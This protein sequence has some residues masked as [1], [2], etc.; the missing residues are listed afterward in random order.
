MSY[1]RE[2]IEALAAYVP[3]EQPAPGEKVV[4]LNT[5]ENP[6]PPSP[7][8][9]EAL[10][11]AEGDSLR[12][13]P[14]PY[15]QMAREAAGRVTGFPPEWILVGNGSDDLLTMLMRSVAEP[16][17]K[18][19][20]PSPTYVLYQTLAEIQDAEVVEVPFDDDYHLPVDALAQANGAV[21]LIANPNSPSGTRADND[22][23]ADLAGK[24]QGLLVVDEAYVDFADGDALALVR[25]YENV[26]VLRTLSKGYS[27]AG[28]RLGFGVA[29]PGVIDGLS[30]V[31]DSYNVNALSCLIGAAALDDQAWKDANAA[32]IRAS[33]DRLTEALEAL[34]FRVL[35]S[36]ANFLL[37]RPSSRRAGELYEGLKRRGIL[38]RYFDRPHLADKLRITVGTDEQNAALIAAL[39]E[40]AAE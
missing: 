17:R 2:N 1:F 18:V 19:V 27:M 40:I 8:A 35:R 5:N 4:K 36:Q 31:K 39:K 37:A 21:T 16:G 20:F 24:L 38:V 7:A 9:M 28:L 14:H 3:G 13:Y 10:R 11:A 6:Y 12:R 15:A 34:G 22:A 30:K 23:L 29:Q 26:L 33:R 25:E 32:K